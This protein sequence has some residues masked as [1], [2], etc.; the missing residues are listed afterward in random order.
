MRACAFLSYM[1]ERE[2]QWRHLV[3]CF[4]AGKRCGK[5]AHRFASV[6][7]Q[8]NLYNTSCG[9]LNADKG[10]FIRVHQNIKKISEFYSHLIYVV[11]I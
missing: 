10:L 6:S 5:V 8:L 11:S 2:G 1:Q 7:H 9:G 3:M 4:S